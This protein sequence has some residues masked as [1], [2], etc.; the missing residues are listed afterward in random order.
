MTAAAILSPIALKT[1]TK[2]GECKRATS[3]FFD[4]RSALAGG[5][6]AHCK[7]CSKKARQAYYQANAD[8][9]K[10]AS[11]EYYRKNTEA[12]LA[13]VTAYY[14]K[15]TDVALQRVKDYRASNQE[16]I[17][18]ARAG[19]YQADK[20]KFKIKASEYYLANK[21]RVQVSQ[22]A[23][24]GRNKHRVQVYSAN[25]AEKVKADPL[26]TLQM[27]YRNIV[28]KAW[29]GNGFVKNSRSHEILGC[30]WDEFRTHIERQ[31]TKGMTWERMPEIHLDHIVALSTAQTAADVVALNHFT[32]LRPLWAFDNLSKGAQA[33]NLI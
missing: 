14:K 5:L 17:K 4:K 28:S 29:R 10:A 9:V 20:D 6:T 7:M 11:L 31:F 19:A 24:R 33:T 12:A 30:S 25:Y 21:D 13:R 3:E 27:R 18:T 15:N 1:C 32:N 26:L 16:Q 22:A 23:W 2:C 8:R